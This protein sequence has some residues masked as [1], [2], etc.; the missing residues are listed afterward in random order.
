MADRNA[1]G[2]CIKGVDTVGTNVPITYG[3]ENRTHAFSVYDIV[4]RMP[5][6]VIAHENTEHRQQE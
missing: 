1:K 6:I 3:E 2:A 5:A 4:A